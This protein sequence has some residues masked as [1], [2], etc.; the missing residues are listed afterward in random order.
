MDA[1]FVIGPLRAQD[2]TAFITP[3]EHGG[4]DETA[5]R[6][7]FN[8]Q[9]EAFSCGDAALDRYLRTQITQDLC[10]DVAKPFVIVEVATRRLAG[11][12]TLSTA[13]VRLNDLPPET[14]KRLP[15][16]PDYPAVLIGR[17]AIDHRYQGQGLGS[18]LLIDIFRRAKRI[19][20]EAAVLGIIVD[21]TDDAARTFY[22]K[23][24][25]QRS[26]VNPYRL[27]LPMPTIR[28]LAID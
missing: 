14:F 4:S 10:R 15:R 16:Y 11:Y 23:H 9:N 18:A 24:Q 13:S 22:E 27:I 21:A 19:D 1:P 26:P 8:A 3:S 7:W 20:L 17:L 2:L 12:Y 25:F 5:F 28:Q 6:Q